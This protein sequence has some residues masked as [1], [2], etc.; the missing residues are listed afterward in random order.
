M[1][2]DTAS[3]RHGL[4]RHGLLRHGLLRHGLLRHGLSADA[5]AALDFLRAHER[6]VLTTHIGPDGDALGSQL[7]LGHFLRALGKEV[8][9]LNADPAPYNLDWLPGH[10]DVQVFDQ[11]L[12]QVT[13]LAEADAVVVLDT[14]DEQRL[15]RVGPSV[16]RSG[17]A[18]L[19]IDHHTEPERW[20]D[21]AFVRQTASATGE[22]VYEILAAHGPT[23]I[24]R[25][26]AVNLY[27]AIMTDTGSFR[28]GSVTPRLHRIIAA[29]LEEGALDSPAFIHERIY[30]RR[31]MPGLRL[32][33]QML[34]RIRLRYDGRLGYS[35][36][37]QRM[38]EE[39]GASWDEKRGFV[40]DVLSIDGVQAA[41]LFSE[42]NDGAKIS[43]RSEGDVRVDRWARAFGGG[44]HRNASG[45]YVRRP[46][47][48]AAAPFEAAVRDVIAAAPKHL[49]W[50]EQ[51]PE[52][53]TFTPSDDLSDDDA[54]YLDALRAQGGSSA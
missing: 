12:E 14:N 52:E 50:A 21:H 24:D 38:V 26:I 36:V 25:A 11:R 23:C 9:L 46:N 41:V 35:V 44:G 53:P 42:T 31:S 39:T 2:S 48:P 28:Y 51:H 5:R 29:L 4:P 43:F 3:S 19:L 30:D 1:P 32:L 17:A 15:G 8:T 34:G 40:N 37:T 45:A 49:G 20:F 54:A 10:A 6:F 13:A 16:R 33:G 18:T 27:T 22:L 7:A 47:D